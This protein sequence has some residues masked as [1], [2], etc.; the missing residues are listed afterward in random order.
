MNDEIILENMLSIIGNYDV[1]DFIARVS[2][3]NLIQHNQNKSIV[4]DIIIDTILRNSTNYCT[5]KNK[6]SKRKFEDIVN[7]C[8]KLSVSAAIDPIECPFVYR[9]QFYG[10]KLIFSGI[11]THIGYN[12]Q[13]FIDVILKKGGTLNKDFVYDCYAMATFILDTTTRIANELGFDISSLDHYE[14]NDIKYPNSEKKQ[15]ELV[16][17][18]IVDNTNIVRIVGNEAKTLYSCFSETMDFSLA[19]YNNFDFFYRPFIKIDD[20]R[21]IILNPTMLPT[22]LIHYMLKKSKEYGVYDDLIEMYNNECFCCCRRYLSNLQHNKI[23][24]GEFG[25]ELVNDPNYKELILNICNDGILFLRFFC[26]SGSDYD[27]YDMFSM[28]T[29]DTSHVGNRLSE[30]VSRMPLCKENRIY[31]ITI[32]N[33]FGRGLLLD[34]DQEQVKNIALSPFELYCVSI[35]EYNHKNFIPRY[36]ECKSLLMK[37]YN[38]F[39]T[40]INY[41]TIFTSNKHSFYMADDI[42]IKNT[43]MHIG[44]GDSIDYISDALKKEN[45][46]LIEFPN[47]EFLREVVVND[48][49]RNIYCSTDISKF[50]LL[51]RFSNI[52]IWITSEPPSSVEMLNITHTIMDLISYWLSELHAVIERQSFEYDSFEIRIVLCGDIKDYSLLKNKY[53]DKELHVTIQNNIIILNWSPE[54]FIKLSN[55]TN[56]QEKELMLLISNA[57]FK[58]AGTKIAI[59]HLNY[60]FDNPLKKKVF[61]IDYMNHPYLKPIGTDIRVIPVECEDFL[62][63]EIG[64]YFI[65]E[66]HIQKGTKITGDDRKK[67]CNDTVSYLFKK[68]CATVEDFQAE[69]LIKLLCLDLEKTMYSMMLSRKR[70]A[71]DLI[72]YPEKSEKL[73]QQINELNKS[74]LSQK[75]LLEYVSSQPPKGNKILGEMDYEELLAICSAIIDWANTS[76]LFE[77][78]II[79]SEMSVLPSGR[80][81]I[82]KTDID[83]LATLRNNSAMSK[84]HN[85]SNPYIDKYSVDVLSLQAPDELES[86][87]SE[88]FGYGFTDFIHCVMG[89]IAL[90]EEIESDVKC[91]TISDLYLRI[92]K[93]V[94]LEESTVIKIIDD[95]SLTKRKEYLIVPKPFTKNDIWPWKFNRKLSVTRRPMVQLDEQII[96]GNR[97][98]Y[99]CLLYTMDLIN[100]ARLPVFNQKGKLKSLLGKIANYGGNHFND[101]VASKLKKIEGL[102]VD[103][104]VKKINGIRILD[105]NKQDI[106]DIDV[107]I[108][109]VKKKKIIIAEVKDFSFSKSPYEM[110]QEYLKVFC[111][112][113]DKLC[114]I[115]KHKRRVEWMKKHLQDIII[116]YHLDPVKWKIDD[117]LIVNEDIVCNEYYHLEQ[118]ILLY[119][120]I[121]QSSINR[122]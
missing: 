55:D 90:G 39:L 107:M 7:N 2:S 61:S 109:N 45:K 24:E 106:G 115:S 4:F 37:Q 82:D 8:M 103:S 121:S 60:A 17:S 50:E 98:L 118:K 89:V 87:F 44:F 68:L 11:N 97:Q 81:G 77:Y 119:S 1:Y 20:H 78:K 76:D 23:K 96:W 42:D 83:K 111:D 41:I 32:I 113:N 122:I 105:D 64:N 22:F 75:F 56:Q 57:L 112:Q 104:K 102:I 21:S 99:H 34:F 19:S 71:Y 58:S 12:L 66:K 38:P 85:N 65:Y 18:V 54:N 35:N 95:L 72:C 9:I 40:D 69:Q 100:D 108:I 67:V 110:Y 88:E 6:M 101:A 14:C 79:N 80:I 117:I 51:N 28:T 13:I 84:V 43:F 49:L 36:I 94:D 120:D 73:Q 93:Y 25:I 92:S 63:N 10:N 52:D 62:L 16:N 47:S 53:E 116:H 15:Q 70:Y 26:D 59:E 29:I 5:S 86:A 46:Q 91:L 114:Y 74:S 31:Q 3:L 27:L 30:I 33:T 48:K